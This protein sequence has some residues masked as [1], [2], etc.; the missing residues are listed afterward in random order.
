MLQAANLIHDSKRIVAFTGAG[1]SVE[2]GLTITNCKSD[3][4]Y[5]KTWFTQ[6]YLTLEVEMD[7]GQNITL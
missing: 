7:F 3:Q 6:V 5:C 1:I 2:S 4:S